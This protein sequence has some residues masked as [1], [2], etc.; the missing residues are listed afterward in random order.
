MFV[1]FDT[2]TTGTNTVFD[3]VL[4]FA[5]ILTNDQLEEVD[6]FEIRCRCLP[7]IVPAPMAL[8]VTGVTP[9]MLDDQSLPSFYDM[10]SAI[11]KKL[12][13]WGPAIYAGYNSMRFDEPLMQRALWQALHPPYLTVTN[14]NAR[15]DILP[16]VQAASHLFEGVFNYPKTPRGRTGFKLD[17]LAPLNGFAHENAHDAL[18]DVEA[19]IFIARILAEKCSELWASNVATTGKSDMASKLA[20]GE[21]FLFVEYF[22][23]GPSVWWGQRIDQHGAS[24]SAASCLRLDANWN[25]IFTLDDEALQKQLTTSPK[26][27]RDIALNKAP[28]V[29]DQATA[30]ALGY[31]PDADILAQSKFLASSEEACAKLLQT[32]A[33]LKEP[34]P[35]AEHLEQRIFEGFPSRE[36]TAR[37]EEFH[38]VDWPGKAAL[39]RSFEDERLQQLAQRLVYASA[40]E[41]LSEADRKSMADAIAV[42]LHDDHGDPD[43]WRTIPQ[44]IEELSEVRSAQGGDAIA[45]EIEGW[46]ADV[47]SRYP[48]APVSG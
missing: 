31:E 33:A 17:Q 15:M 8:K 28:I 11:R 46:L 13:N 38:R 10:M 22:I 32:A 5:A 48:A 3:Q 9:D 41:A 47:E 39:I 23:S 24:T 40:P 4:Q 30:R 2:E 42:R 20:P 44:A 27:L 37:M 43:L 21:P 16:L 25:E 29:F 1:F 26:P 19:T 45:A 18:A 6:R 14:N 34:W 12:E 36:D 7:W 35:E